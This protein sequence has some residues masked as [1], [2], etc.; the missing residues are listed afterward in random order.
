MIIPQNNFGDLQYN[1]ISFDFNFNFLG[2]PFLG[3]LQW[4]HFHSANCQV[5]RLFSL[6]LPAHLRTSSYL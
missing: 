2:S 1:N 3:D 5:F 6:I 4:E